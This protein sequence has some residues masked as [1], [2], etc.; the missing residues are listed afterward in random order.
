MV[1]F[2]V[3]S[4]PPSQGLL[5]YS[6][7]LNYHTLEFRPVNHF[8][9]HNKQYHRQVHV[10]LNIFVA[11]TVCFHMQGEKIEFNHSTTESIT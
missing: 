1:A 8:V 3:S 6:Y 5:N 2:R 4:Q 10:L 11:F 7:V 9:P